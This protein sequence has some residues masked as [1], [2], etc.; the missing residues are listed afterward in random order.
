MK[1]QLFTSLVLL[2]LLGC[3]GSGSTGSKEVVV[4]VAEIPD[5]R[6][7]EHYKVVF[8]GNSHSNSLPALVEILIRNGLP[9]KTVVAEAE[10]G[11]LFLDERVDHKRS[12]ELLTGNDWTHV[13]LQAQ[14]YSQSGLVT[15]STSAA[16]SWVRRAKAQQATPIMFPEHAQR[17][18]LA[19]GRRIHAL[20][21][22]IAAAEATCVAPVGLA[23]DKAL[24]LQPDLRLHSSDG[25]HAALAG[26]LLSSLVFYEVITGESADLLPYIAE[27]DVEASTQDFLGQ[28][29]SEA[30]AE[31][32]ACRFSAP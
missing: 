13:I 26:G 2:S 15:Y 24:E 28:V 16:E 7:T 10:P 23:W 11:W 3:G 30:L 25:N 12:L 29:A 20:H 18:R 4:N 19:E 9:H 21:L 5:N 17:G 1:K 22:S 6:S 14:K 32:V 31:H 8:F 27:I